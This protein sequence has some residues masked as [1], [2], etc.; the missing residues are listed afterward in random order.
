[1]ISS[2]N[3][4]CW[5]YHVLNRQCWYIKFLYFQM[6]YGG[7]TFIDCVTHKDEELMTWHFQCK[8]GCN[9]V[10]CRPVIFLKHQIFGI[11]ML[12]N[13][14]GL[15]HVYT[16]QKCTPDVFINSYQHFIREN[17]WWCGYMYAAV[18]GSTALVIQV[19][20]MLCNQLIEGFQLNFGKG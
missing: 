18:G 9:T 6:I 14:E 17:I 15:M 16:V 5:W 1:M 10:Y 4:K 12:V 8:N 7:M 13:S 3:E 19:V 20:C 2:L 11:L